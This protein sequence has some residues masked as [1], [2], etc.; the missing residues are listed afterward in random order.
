MKTMHV[1]ARIPIGYNDFGEY[2]LNEAGEEKFIELIS[3]RLPEEAAWC[4]DE[5]LAPVD[6]GIEIDIK[7]IIAEAAEEMLREYGGDEFFEEW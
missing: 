6:S 3:K 4:G 5:I 7:E 2:E 1:I